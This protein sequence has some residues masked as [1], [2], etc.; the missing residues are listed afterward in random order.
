MSLLV[1]I[2]SLSAAILLGAPIAFALLASGV[3]LMIQLDMLNGQIVAQNLL[4]GANNY[5]LLSVPF[6]LLAGELMN[7]GGLS[8]RIVAIPLALVGHV[9][10]GLG[11][12]VIVAALFL[13]SLS[14][15][16]IADA[17][18]LAA[19]LLP[20]MRRGGYSVESSTGLVAAASL[21]APIFPPSVPFVL[22]GITANV[23]ITKLFAA[24]IVP[25]FLLALALAAA[26][27]W[28]TRRDNPEPLPKVEPGEL[29]KAVLGAGWALGLPVIIL[30]GLRL[31]AFTPTEAGAVAAT[32]ALFVGGV[33]Y[34]EIDG[35][36]LV[37]VFV[38]VGRL[39][40][41]LMFLVAAAFVSTW[42]IG[43]AN[44]SAQISGLLSPL[45]GSPLLLMLA[46]NALVFLLGTVL[47][48]VPAIL[49]LT[50]LLMPLIQK[51]GIDPVYFGVLFILNNAIG[52]IT[53]PVGP[54]LNAVC[55][56]GR[57]K[58]NTVIA[59]ITPFLVAETAVLAL[60][61]FFP[62]LVTVPMKALH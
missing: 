46:L 32:Y 62:W 41:V 22:F 29:L 60:L 27:W 19:L 40:A 50:P 9:R 21:V 35:R 58:M 30:G 4:N 28:T 20:M 11:Y 48:I 61:I 56:V 10:G 7:A 57:V 38:Q 37:E 18:A 17:S 45:L 23:S 59:G 55:G 54:V 34:R 24:G 36:G 12:V 26:W 47:D 33:V 8:R 6:F 13:A 16:A 44:V 5:A 14:G 42:L 52:M 15:S 25:A 53:P 1:L 51:A 3:A 2:G 31:G 39:S 49:L 43:A